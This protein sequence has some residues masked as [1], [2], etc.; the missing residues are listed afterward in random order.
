MLATPA[1]FLTTPATIHIIT[2]MVAIMA[3][4]TVD[5]VGQ[6]VAVAHIRTRPAQQSLERKASYRAI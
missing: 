3:G 4:S 1:A 2:D 6:M 5:M